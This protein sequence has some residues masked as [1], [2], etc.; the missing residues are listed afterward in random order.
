MKNKF[1]CR[2]IELFFFGSILFNIPAMAQLVSGGTGH[3]VAVCADGSMSAWGLNDQ[4]EIGQGTVSTS[5]CFCEATALPIPSISG[6][7]AVGAGGS[8]TLA[9][10]NNG[11]IKAWG[12]NFDGEL[13]NGM[14]TTSG[15]FCEM[16]IVDVLGMT[17]VLAVASGNISSHA[18][19]DD[20][21]VW[22]WGGDNFGQLGD[23][24]ANLTG[25]FCELTPVQAVGLSGITAIAAGSFHVLALKNDSTVWTWG[26]N[27]NGQLGYVGGSSSA[28][29]T[30]ISINNV[31]AIAAGQ[32]FSYALKSDG[33][34]WAWGDNSWGQLGISG[35]IT[36]TQVVGINNVI[37]IGN[38]FNH[39]IALRSDSTVW[40][41]GA[42]YSGQLGQGNTTNSPTPAQ[43]PGLTGVAAIGG[44]MGNFCIAIK[45]DGTVW[46]WGDNTW[47]SVGN[48]STTNALSPVP[49]QGLCTIPTSL[50]KESQSQF[51]IY[52][53]PAQEGTS[54]TIEL[55]EEFQN[56]VNWVE[57]YNATGELVQRS[58][59]NKS[60]KFP[61]QLSSGI[62]F[63]SLIYDGKITG[64]KLLVE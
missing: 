19:K 22:G 2:F 25:C 8:H 42:N 26:S 32:N 64:K 23:G 47:G 49:V 41:W 33:S 30:Q 36:P 14:Q 20:G 5:G 16:N 61:L 29:P 59:W 24:N 15:C 9:L 51:Q 46:S 48:G 50:E 63:V 17:N 31:I 27:S 10:M 28:T 1:T 21:T 6:G 54:L 11:T 7:A 62:Y 37:A 38:S 53:N 4:N 13:G 35:G 40:T 18:L 44:T 3:S 55:A 52:P 58:H 39:A 12:R 57:I 60:G 43:V 34:V 45:A 56:Q